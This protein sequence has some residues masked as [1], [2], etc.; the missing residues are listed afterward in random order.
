MEREKKGKKEYKGT[1][2]KLKVSIREVRLSD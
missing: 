1:L 2:H